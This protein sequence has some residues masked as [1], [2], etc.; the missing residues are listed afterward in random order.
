MP[1]FT[2]PN[3][4]A[5]D[6]VDPVDG[7]VVAAVAEAVAEV[8]DA[9]LLAELVGPHTGVT[10]DHI[11]HRATH[12]HGTAWTDLDPATRAARLAAT[13]AD[14]LAEFTHAP[15]PDDLVDHAH[16]A[17]PPY[18]TG[19]LEHAWWVRRLRHGITVAHAMAPSH[20]AR[21]LGDLDDPS[22]LVVQRDAR[23]DD[24]PYFRGR[25]AETITLLE[26]FYGFRV[27]A[28]TGRDEVAHWI[29]SQQARVD[30]LSHPAPERP[31]VRGHYDSARLWLRYFRDRQRN[32][33]RPEGWQRSP[34][35]GD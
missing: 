23:R 28:A 14:M 27:P 10:H 9:D 32:H 1:E 34:V 21:I 13:A 6:Q 33:A 12:D 31:F 5:V 26:A 8:V 18:P 19:V 17:S 35:Q 30:A 7:D 4:A 3:P 24:D 11:H 15:A 22:T 16:P 20:G 25:A 29:R 2:S